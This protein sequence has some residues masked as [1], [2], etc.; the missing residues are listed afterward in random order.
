VVGVEEFFDDWENV[1]GIH[2]N[3]SFFCHFVYQFWLFVNPNSA[4]TGFQNYSTV[5]K[6]K[7]WQKTKSI[8]DDLAI[9]DVNF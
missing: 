5:R 3:G 8:E 6:R 1:F 4:D 2:R 7:F 9:L